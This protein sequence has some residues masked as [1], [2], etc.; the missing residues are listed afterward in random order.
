MQ[1]GWSK[2]EARPSPFF[3]IQ[4]GPNDSS[5]DKSLLSC[6]VLPYAALRC[7]LYVLYR[8]VPHSKTEPARAQD[9][10]H[11]GDSQGQRVKRVEKG[12][13]FD[14]ERERAR[15]HCAIWRNLA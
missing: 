5:R 9:N 4:K 10:R 12:Q 14:T 2:R 8:T 6:P 3:A 11:I 1:H 7:T 13:I 15:F